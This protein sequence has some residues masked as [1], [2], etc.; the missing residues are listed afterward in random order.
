M[1]LTADVLLSVRGALNSLQ[2][3]ECVLRDLSIPAIENLAVLQDQF[4]HIDLTDNEVMKLENLPPMKRLSSIF[5]VNNSVS[6]ISKGLGQMV[7]RLKVVDLTGNQLRYLSEVRNLAEFKDL[8]HLSL[9][10]NPVI[11]KPLYRLFMLYC[12]PSLKFLDFQRITA[13]EREDAKKVFEGRKGEEVMK[14]VDEEAKAVAEGQGAVDDEP[15]AAE[16][17]AEQKARVRAAISAAKSKIELERI[18]LQVQTGTFRFDDWNVPNTDQAEPEP[19]SE[20]PAPAPAPAPEKK[21]KKRKGSVAEVPP[22]DCIQ[23]VEESNGDK[24][25]DPVA[26]EEEASEAAD[27]PRS[28]AR[29][30]SSLGS[31]SGEQEAGKKEKK[32]KGKTRT[33]RSSSIASEDPAGGGELEEEKE[34]EKEGEEAKPKRKRKKAEDASVEDKVGETKATAK[35]KGKKK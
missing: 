31:Q 30:S 15:P 4:D 18:E 19:S 6:R 22:Q 24:A 7:P 26:E 20:A 21:S 23:E 35:K 28:Q 12:I 3:R 33:K 17:T 14:A 29:R 16:L 1:R 34:K 9:C 27:K 10:G 2:D 8:E 25:R 11:H 13:Q 5:L 32:A